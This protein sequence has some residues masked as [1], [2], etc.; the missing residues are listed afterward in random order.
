[1][2]CVRPLS[3]KEKDQLYGLLDHPK[4]QVRKRAKAVLL[5]SEGYS[6]NQMVPL[7]N[8]LVNLTAK[9]IRKRRFNEEGV[10]G[11]TRERKSPGA[12]V[13]ITKEQRRRMVELA[14]TPPRGLGKPFTNWSLSKLKEHLAQEGIK[15]SRSWKILKEEGVSLQGVD[16][17]PRSGVCAQKKRVEGLV[18][19][20]PKGAEVIFFDEKR[21]CKVK[22]YG[23][24]SW[25]LKRGPKK[26]PAKHKVRGWLEV[27]ASL[28]VRTGK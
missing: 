27:F 19:E 18:K 8:L 17:E 13:R 21:A 26:V 10:E 2:L 15:V 24:R 25:G 3:R 9:S 1:M 28:D 12:P 22:A 20:P 7:V 16:P 6:A 23:G 4:P 14:L 5:S 11:L